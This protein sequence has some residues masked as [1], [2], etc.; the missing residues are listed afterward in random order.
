[1]NINTKIASLLLTYRNNPILGIESLFNI[2][3]DDQQKELVLAASDPNARVAVKSGQGCGKALVNGE[4]VLTPRGF[5]KIEDLKVGDK[6][7]DTYSSTSTI[8]GVY[9]QGEKDCYRVFFS[10]GR[11]S[12][13]SIDHLWTVQK[14][15]KGKW[16]TLSLEEILESGIH[17]LQEKTN[18]NPKGYSNK[19]RIP[20][21]APVYY[22]K[23]NLILSPYLLGVWLGDGCRNTGSITNIDQDL[24]DSIERLGYTIGYQY[25][26]T[27]LIIGLKP[28]LRKLQILDKYSFERS[29]PTEYLTSSIED[30]LELLQGLMDTDGTISPRGATTYYTTSKTLANDFITLIRSLGC[31]TKGIN[32]KK[33]THRDCYTIHFRSEHL[34][35]V[36]K[37]KRKEER[38]SFTRLT[39]YVTISS[40]VYLGKKECTCISVESKNHLFI[41]RDFIPTHNTMTLVCLTM[42]FLL[43]LED[44]RILITAPSAQ[45]LD[46]VFH[47]EFLKWYSRLPEMFKNFFEVKKESIH[48]KG[49]PFQMASLVTGNPSNIEG[50]RGGHATNYIIF[51]DEAS[52][53][54]EKVFDTLNGTLGTGHGRFILTSNPTRNSGRFYEI[55]ASENKRWVRLTFSGL[56]SQQINHSWIED[57]KAMYSE[58]DDN[59]QIRVLG[60]FGRFGEQQFIPSN[61]IESSIKNYLDFRAYSNF[62]KVMGVDVARF[63]DDQTVFVVRQGPKVLDIVKFSQLDTMEVAGRIVDMQARHNCATIFIDSVGIGAGVY[64]RSRELGLP[65]KE[66]I[67]SHKSTRPMMYANL[68]AQLW[69]EFRDWLQNGGDI[70]DDKELSSQLNSMQYTLNNKMQI[71]LLSKRDI[72]KMGLPSPD[73][74][75]AISLTFAGNIYSRSILT[76]YKRNIKRSNYCWV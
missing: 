57:M 7:C 75:D 70:P 65:V 51:G 36:F 44:C 37:I 54:E 33:T 40:A 67:V 27:K 50:I 58:E 60:N 5:K 21:I 17:E 34:P 22:P 3:L 11:Y 9:P 19:F 59:Y 14:G 26:Q 10:D 49:K 28:K 73:I 48:I 74:G 68:R 29:I 66:V 18:R 4:P 43:T 23:N 30:R 38:R 76:N 71:L 1:M 35:K 2:K 13:C 47:S 8:S 20:N 63:G 6:V 56:N 52:G 55:F 31:F 25:Y 32:I 42:L 69:G 45:L 24:W 62:P 46:R 61:L 16:I 72:K 15:R 41:T 64:D 53:L 39:S 12:D